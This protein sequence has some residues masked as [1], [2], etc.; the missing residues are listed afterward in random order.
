MLTKIQIIDA[1]HQLNRTATPDWLARFDSVRL[2]RYLDHLQVTLEPRGRTS[3]WV[4]PRE[5]RA[6]VTRPPLI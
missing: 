3:I 5:T 2:H 1:I 6:V 4:R